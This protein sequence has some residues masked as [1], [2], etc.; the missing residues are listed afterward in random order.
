MCREREKES[1][2]HPSRFMGNWLRPWDFPGKRV[3]EWG[4]GKPRIQKSAYAQV[5][6]RKEY[7]FTYNLYILPYTSNHLCVTT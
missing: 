4:L 1:T 5:A 7:M 2:F 6:C 3:L